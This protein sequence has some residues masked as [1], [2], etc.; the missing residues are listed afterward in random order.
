ATG[1]TPGA[2]SSVSAN[3]STSVARSRP[4]YAAFSVRISASSTSERLSSWRRRSRMRSTSSP[5]PWTY[6][7]HARAASVRHETVTA[8]R[9]SGPA[10]VVGG[11]VLGAL[12]GGDD[13][14]HQA[15]A[16]D[17]ALAE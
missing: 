14:L 11:L 1:G 6:A 8:M 2:P 17:V 15:M 12:V 3:A 13:V 16:H 4:R 10:P 5:R 9:P 7:C